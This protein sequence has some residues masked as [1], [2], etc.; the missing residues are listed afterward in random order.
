MSVFLL[1]LACVHIYFAWIHAVK[2]VSYPDTPEAFVELWHSR[3]DRIGKPARCSVPAHLGEN[4]HLN[5]NKP[6]D[7]KTTCRS[8]GEQ[9]LSQHFSS[10]DTV[11][12]GSESAKALTCEAEG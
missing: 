11:Y 8:C 4:P 6:T 10:G 12:G 2:T 9:R 1:L 3:V 5:I 7:N